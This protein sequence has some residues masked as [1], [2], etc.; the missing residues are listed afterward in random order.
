[1][2]D[3]IKFKVKFHETLGCNFF[4]YA[5]NFRQKSSVGGVVLLRDGCNGPG[6]VDR[7]LGPDI[8]KLIYVF[9]AI[10]FIRSLR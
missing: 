3:E 8:Y 7:I 2:S 6:D 10:K 1:M 9:D 4:T 5:G